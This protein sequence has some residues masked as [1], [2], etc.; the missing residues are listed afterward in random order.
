MTIARPWVEVVAP[1]DL[2]RHEAA[3][4]AL[5]ARAAEPN[6]FADY[7]FLEPALRRLAP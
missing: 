7:A 4:R 1:G 5:E 6:V 3:W 2:A